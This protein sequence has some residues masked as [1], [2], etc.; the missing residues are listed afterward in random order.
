MLSARLPSPLSTGLGR[1]ARHP[2]LRLGGGPVLAV[3]LLARLLY[4]PLQALHGAG[5]DFVSFATGSRILASGS[6]C[7]YCLST[8]ADAQ[9]SVLGYRPPA[10]AT[11]F[12]HIF[13]NPPLAAWVLR[14]LASLPLTTGLALF[15]VASLAALLA[16][17][18][19]LERWLPRSISEGRRG[20][21]VI[22]ATA[23]LPAATTLLLGQWDGFLL[24]AAAGALWALDRERPLTAGLLLSV[25]LVK[26][27][28]A[29]L[30]LPVLLA[31]SRWRVAAGF[32]LGAATWVGSALLIVG[33]RQLVELV[34][35]VRTRLP[36]D[37]LVSAGLP[38]LAGGIG[39]STAVLIAAPVLA[40]VSVAI[41]WRCRARLRRA[42]PAL[43]LS[44]GICAS[45]LCAPH[46]FSDDLLLLAVPLVVLATTSPRAALAGAVALS[47]AFVLDEWVANLGP[48]WAEAAVV[49]AVAGCLL[50]IPLATAGARLDPA[51]AG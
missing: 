10:S 34:S 8:Q 15:L 25:L 22:A 42:T 49:L 11:G 47:A 38:A 37:G 12:P 19:L 51:S 24:L 36:G 6:R 39:G 23:S 33:P 26:P 9:A 18:R 16:G 50:R 44:L 29:W 2:V 4:A 32:A 5:S 3:I 20:L 46:V 17:A 30:L 41:A 43:A 31:A 7:L 48:R 45:I 21:L 35:L 1:L 14:P 27:Q 28:L 13:V 40:A